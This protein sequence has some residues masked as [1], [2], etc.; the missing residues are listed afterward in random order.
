MEGI[1][2]GLIKAGEYKLAIKMMLRVSKERL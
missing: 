1:I 2:K